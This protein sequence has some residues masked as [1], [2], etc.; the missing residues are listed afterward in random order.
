[1]VSIIAGV[2][3]AG[4]AFGVALYKGRTGWHWFVATLFA[5]STLWVMSAAALY[6]AGMHPPFALVDTDLAAF[7]GGLTAIVVLIILVAV[8]QRPRSHTA[9]VAAVRRGPTTGDAT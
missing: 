8:P 1:M 5:F 4:S 6:L 7:V 3:V 9:S 2:L